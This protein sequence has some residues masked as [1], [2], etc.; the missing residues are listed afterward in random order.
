VAFKPSN[1][2]KHHFTKLKDDHKTEEKSSVIYKVDCN[3]GKSYIGQSSRKLRDRVN[4]H[5]GY[6]RKKSADSALAAHELNNE[7]HKFDFDNITI[8][9]TEK[10]RSKRETK[11]TI[12]IF[13]N[14][15]KVVNKRQDVEGF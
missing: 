4:D 8:M 10:I 15:Q 12:Q 1:Q 14:K 2:I 9:Q 6:I 5:K 7:N 3:C 11:E 13:K